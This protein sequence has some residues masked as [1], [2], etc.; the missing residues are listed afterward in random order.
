[1][2]ETDRT[3]GIE[4]P[5]VVLAWRKIAAP[6]DDI[7]RRM[8]DVGLPHP[9]LE[10][11]DEL[12]GACAVLVGGGG[13]KE[14]QRVGQGIGAQGPELR[15]PE[16]GAVVFAYV[17]ARAASRKRNVELDAARDE[18]DFSWLKLDPS[19][20]RMQKQSAQLRHDKQFAVGV[21]KETIDHVDVGR[22]AVDSHPRLLG[23]ISV[24][25]VGE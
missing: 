16:R 8:L 13:R 20:F 5:K 4:S 11:L 2:I 19:E 23:N 7:E 12:E 1:M 6:R 3:H 22:V 25:C 10:F 18:A 15:E 9:A 17:T 21:E 14:V 24:T